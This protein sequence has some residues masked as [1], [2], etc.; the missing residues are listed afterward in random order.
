MVKIQFDCYVKIMFSDNGLEFSCMKDYFDHNG[1]IFQTLCV[2]TPQ[3]NER[4]ERKHQYFKCCS[5]I[6]VIC[7]LPVSFWGECVLCVSS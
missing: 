3:Q 6:D 2:D 4:V 7:D 1:I 5:C